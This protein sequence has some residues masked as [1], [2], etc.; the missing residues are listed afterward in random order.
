MPNVIKCG[1]DGLVD[2]GILS[3][4][5][6]PAIEGWYATQATP[7]A[8]DAPANADWVARYTKT[9]G[10]TPTLYSINA[11][12]AV[13]VI[14]DAVTRVA[15]SGKPVNHDTVRDAIQDANTKTLQG[16]VS[17]DENGDITNKVISVWQIHHDPSFPEDDVSHQ[18]KYIGDA[19]E[20]PAS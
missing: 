12:D 7:D 16:T 17:F 9:Y 2:G 5:G 15:A 10:M 11:Y 20:A 4:V 13:M 19:P 3:A 8:L 18:L 6:F 14:A 1:G